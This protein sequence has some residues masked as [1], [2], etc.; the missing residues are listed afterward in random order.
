LENELAV[1]LYSEKSERR[2]F[3]AV[4]TSSAF[5]AMRENCAML[6]SKRDSCPTSDLQ[7]VLVCL[8]ESEKIGDADFRFRQHSV[9]SIPDALACV[10]LESLGPDI[11]T[12][13]DR[14]VLV[15]RSLSA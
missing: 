8:H 1:R 7:V 3:G 15:C 4:L 11:V 10:N 13:S 5:S 9:D 14:L 12:S 2:Y 6:L